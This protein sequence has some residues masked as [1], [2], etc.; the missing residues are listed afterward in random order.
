MAM[1]TQPKCKSV[2]SP[3]DREHLE[4]NACANENDIKK[5]EDEWLTRIECEYAESRAEREAS[6]VEGIWARGN[7]SRMGSDDYPSGKGDGEAAE[8][9]DG[10][11][12]DP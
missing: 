1:V 5:T 12:K 3:A 9:A 2:L 4:R 6:G 8:K 11:E 10:A 7:I